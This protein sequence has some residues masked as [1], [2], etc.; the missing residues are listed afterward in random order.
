MNTVNN[1]FS[2]EMS[3]PDQM[4]KCLEARMEQLAKEDICLAFSGGVD[5]SLLLKTAAD[6]AAHT[7]RKVYAA[8]ILPATWRLPGAWQG[9]WE[10]SMRL[11]PWMSWS[12]SQ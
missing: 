10:E 12:R 1:S 4:K 6:A 3:S 9:S 11:L 5:S 2:D 8:C 7:G